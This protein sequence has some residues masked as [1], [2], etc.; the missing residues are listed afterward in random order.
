MEDETQVFVVVGG[1]GSRSNNWGY[2]GGGATHMSL[3]TGHL[4]NTTVRNDILLVAGRR[5]RK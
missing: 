3:S 4:T 2:G 5:W 1:Q